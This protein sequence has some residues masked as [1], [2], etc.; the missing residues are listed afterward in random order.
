[1]LARIKELGM[2]S[3]A[4][5]DHGTLSGAIEF[6]KAARELGLKPIIG[7]EAYVAPRGLENKSGKIDANPY[8]LILLASSNIGYS[9]LMKLSSLAHLDGFYYRPRI[10]RKLLE[11]N[12]EGIIVLSGCAGGEVATHLRNGNYELAKEVA[13]WY[14]DTFGQD[15]YF[16]ELQ[17]HEHQWPEQKSIN[18]GLRKL[19]N[20]TGVEMVVTADSHYCQPTD[21]EA[22]EILLCVQTGKTVG[23]AD[24]M[25]MDREILRS[26]GRMSLKH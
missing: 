6:Y 16:L 19:S 15:N 22:H 2:T 11:E 17:D 23:D 10:D 24:R 13:L 14:R 21:R 25:T 7:I 9:N 4:L 1:M 3:V 26:V 5:T 20:D 12:H 8:H 18:D